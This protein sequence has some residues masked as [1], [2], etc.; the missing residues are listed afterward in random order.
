MGIFCSFLLP[1]NTVFYGCIHCFTGEIYSEKSVLKQLH[2]HANIIE[3][4]Y[5]ADIY[6]V[7]PYNLMKPAK[8]MWYVTSH[9]TVMQHATI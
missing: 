6:A 5:T 1:N 3:G 7:R 9:Y 2:H 8:Y 4:T